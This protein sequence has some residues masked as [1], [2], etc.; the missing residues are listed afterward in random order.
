MSSN[1]TTKSPE[2]ELSDLREHLETLEASTNG[3]FLMAFGIIIFLMQVRNHFCIQLLFDRW[4]LSIRM[5]FLKFWV[6]VTN[7]FLEYNSPLFVFS[8]AVSPSLRPAPF[9]QRTRSTF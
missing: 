8:R 2:D 6:L 7:V 3:F 1:A 9:G 5:Y 4:C